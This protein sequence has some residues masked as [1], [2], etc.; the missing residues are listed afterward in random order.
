MNKIFQNHVVIITTDF[1]QFTLMNRT[2]KAIKTNPST[3]LGHHISGKTKAID[4]IITK[5]SLTSFMF[6]VAGCEKQRKIFA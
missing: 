5:H 3:L 6:E 2:L 1:I 4:A